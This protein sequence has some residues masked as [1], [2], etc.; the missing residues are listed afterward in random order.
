MKVW[1]HFL[2]RARFPVNEEL[3]VK[4]VPQL[5]LKRDV[6]VVP[7]GSVRWIEFD[8]LVL[9]E[10]VNRRG[11][12]MNFDQELPI[13]LGDGFGADRRIDIACLVNRRPAEN[14]SAGRRLQARIVSG[15]GLASSTFLSHNK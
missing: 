4:T 6:M 15:I 14:L 5:H 7:S 8:N 1:P 12:S 13:D 11:N 10:F 9:F 2:H 3:A